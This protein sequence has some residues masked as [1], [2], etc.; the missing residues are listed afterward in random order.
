MTAE[1]TP[2]EI[3]RAWGRSA[4]LKDDSERKVAR[5]DRAV[6]QIARQIT[7][8]AQDRQQRTRFRSRVAV[9][10][11][12]AAVVAIV[13][14]ARAL[15]RRDSVSG[16][17]LADTAAGRLFGAGSVIVQRAGAPRPAAESM[18]LAPGDEVRT[19]AESGTRIVLADGAE[20]ALEAKSRL[21]LG[22][23]GAD[24]LELLAGELTVTVPKLVPPRTF[25]VRTPDARVVV[26]GTRFVV[27]IL[28]APAKPRTRVRVIEGKVGV[29]YRGVVADLVVGQT[30]PAAPQKEQ[31]TGATV[32]EPPSS[33]AAAQPAAPI[34]SAD[35][36]SSPGAASQKGAAPVSAAAL[37]EQNRLFSAAVA[38]SRR[39]DDARAIALIDELLARYPSSPLLP[40]ARVERFRALKRLGQKSEAA[41]EASRYLLENENGAA[42]DEARSIV[43]PKSK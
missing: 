4:A 21:V 31:A 22:R 14:G 27:T 20:A 5:R 35:S 29:E 42:R 12:A 43:L 34:R 3:L 1:R 24:A 26:H 41:R 36:R 13:F 23:S 33:T 37:A 17:A 8:A 16:P 38:E 32:R 40:E 39:G 15:L 30:W 19:P 2:E 25:A 7:L 18:R 11:A 28:E 9:L 6:A 10:L